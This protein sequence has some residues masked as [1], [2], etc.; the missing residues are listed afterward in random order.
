[1][2]DLS[3]RTRYDV[4]VLSQGIGEDQLWQLLVSQ[5]TSVRHHCDALNATRGK[6]STQAL[7]TMHRNSE[8]PI[9]RTQC[10]LTTEG[11]HVPVSFPVVD[12]AL[13]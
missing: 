3:H 6:I 10:W 13:V 1:L 12:R 7:W 9:A 2:F 5:Y 8:L 4:Q 11:E